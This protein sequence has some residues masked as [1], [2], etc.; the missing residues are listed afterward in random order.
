[1]RPLG[2][3]V[4]PRGEVYFGEAQRN[5]LRVVHPALPYLSLDQVIFASQEGSEVYVFSGTGRHLRTLGALTGAVRY[6]F[7]Y[8]AEGGCWR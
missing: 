6:D 7:A 4:N 1:M 3:A 8:D 5:R 2:L